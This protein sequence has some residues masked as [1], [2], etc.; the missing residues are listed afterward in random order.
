MRKQAIYS[1]PAIDIVE[2]TMENGI[3]QSSQMPTPGNTGEVTYDP[4]NDN[5]EF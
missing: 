2:V 3:A 5:Y 4:V 1:T